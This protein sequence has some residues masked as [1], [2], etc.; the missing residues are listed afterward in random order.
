MTGY[1]AGVLFSISI[2]AG[3][4][5]SVAGGGSFLTFPAL[6]LT[7]IPPIQSNATSTTALWPGT[8]ASFTGYR[9]QLHSEQKKVLVPLLVS[10]FIGGIVG[11]QILLKTPQAT[12]LHM[13]PYLLGIATILF[14][15]SSRI[16]G[17]VRSRSEHMRNMTVAAMIGGA[18]VQLV[19]SVYIGFFGAGAGIIML[20]L[21]AI[22]GVENIHTMNAYKNMMAI[23][24]NGIAMLRFIIAKAVF[25]PQAL[26]M[27]VGA[28]LGGYMGATLAQKMNPRH[29]RVLVIVIGAG[30]S[31]YF[32][33]KQGF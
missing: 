33:W 23:V 7:G 21:F 22:M 9:N 15:F 13:V 11:A 12:F 16:T 25:W 4:L 27:L 24:C 8:I 20:A 14:A 6:L 18:I 2:V 10:A 28:S 3:A 32:F 17:W 29:V 1:D 5:N 31:V 19:I 26:A 30:M